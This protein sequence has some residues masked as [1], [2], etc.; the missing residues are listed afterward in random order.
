[1]TSG[2]IIVIDRRIVW[3]GNIN[4]LSYGSGEFSFAK[5]QQNIVDA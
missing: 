5:K 2:D 1:L 4:L 3:Y